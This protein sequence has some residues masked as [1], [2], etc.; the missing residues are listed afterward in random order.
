MKEIEDFP[1]DNP[2]VRPTTSGGLQKP[3]SRI[4]EKK[5]NSEERE[6]EVLT[7]H[8][9]WAHLDQDSCDTSGIVFRNSDEEAQS[10]T[11]TACRANI[12]E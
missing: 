11:Q 6:Y 9:E 1:E 7:Q 4:R 8:S 10:V 5:L 2:E 3:F 12:I